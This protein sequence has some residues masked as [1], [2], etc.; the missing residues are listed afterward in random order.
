MAISESVIDAGVG[1]GENSA[2]LSFFH[3]ETS[4]ILS[5]CEFMK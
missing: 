4:A 1:V 3:P 5:T 2:Y